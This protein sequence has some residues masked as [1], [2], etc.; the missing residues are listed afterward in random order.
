MKRET[1]VD[2]IAF[3]MKA[4]PDGWRKHS[5]NFWYHKESELYVW[6]ADIGRITFND[7]TYR[8]YPWVT[9]R[10]WFE[11]RKLARALHDLVAEKVERAV[12]AAV[13]KQL[14]AAE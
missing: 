2:S 11:R 6:G 10:K 7:V 8:L 13:T 12:S 4:D 3:S 9:L 14:T 1:A 5:D